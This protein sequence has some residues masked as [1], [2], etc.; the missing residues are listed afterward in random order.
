VLDSAGLNALQ[1]ASVLDSVGLVLDWMPCKPRQ[2]W[3][4]LKCWICDS[5]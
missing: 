1:A 5:S 4:C 2:C 3:K